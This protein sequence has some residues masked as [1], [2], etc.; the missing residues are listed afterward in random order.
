M[1]AAEVAAGAQ[2]LGVALSAGQANQLS[3]YAELLM[4][5]NAVYN[6]TAIEE[7]TDVLT[8]HLLDSLAI[9][10]HVL[11]RAGGKPA[12]VLDVGSGGGL[13]GIPLAVA[14]PSLSVTLLE[15]VGKKAAFLRQAKVELG[16]G[17][18]EVVSNRVEDFQPDEPFDVI[19]SRA[20]AALGDFVALTD[21]L[22]A[23]GGYWAAMKG[24]AAADE[25]AAI[26]AN[27]RVSED[28]SLTVPGLGAQRRL[29]ILERTP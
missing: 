20:F 11:R 12:K 16:L 1:T 10:T 14:A 21:R 24:A 29:L 13:P 27:V 28:L 9:V 6:L 3:N 26:P 2:A 18:V 15:K 4:R 23:A 17:N 5:W 22:L 8:H 25:L 19:A 7:P